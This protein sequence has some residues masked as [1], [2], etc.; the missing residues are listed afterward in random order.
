V[1]A[2]K[3]LSAWTVLDFSDW[4]VK[5]GLLAVGICLLVGL[6]TRTACVAGAAYLLMFYLA[7]PALIGWPDPPR[8][9]GHYVLINKNIIEMLALLTLAT[10]RSGRWAGLDGLVQ[11]LRPSRWRRNAEPVMLESAYREPVGMGR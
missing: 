3:P 6:L 10:T 5:Y 11:F 2:T 8:A 1:R 7:M 9:E 4:L